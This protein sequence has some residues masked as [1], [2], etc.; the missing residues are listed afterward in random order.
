MAL[1]ST[2]GFDVDSIAPVSVPCSLTS[3]WTTA[4]SAGGPATQDAASITNP[5]TEITASTR[6][7][8]KRNRMNGTLV[9]VR[10]GYSGTPSTDPIVGVWGRTGTDAWQR[11]INKSSGTQST[12]A[13]VS[14]SD[15]TDGTLKYTSASEDH[16]FDCVGC[17]EILIGV[18]TAF[19]GSVTA[20]SIIQMKII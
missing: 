9:M 6:R 10:L 3:R 16:T 13:T 5:T 18:E 4:I 2:V 12:L 8:L 7:I 17:E 20:D 19:A 14:A 11:L 15:V 1:S